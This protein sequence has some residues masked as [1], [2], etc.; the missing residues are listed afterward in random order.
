MNQL[1]HIAVE[2][3]TQMRSNSFVR[4]PYVAN[5]KS[6]SLGIRHLFTQ[7]EVRLLALSVVTGTS[8]WP[9]YLYTYEDQKR[10]F[11]VLKNEVG[12][13]RRLAF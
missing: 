8:E 2:L 11:R 10:G 7:R 4:S 5:K 12:A 3:V 1:T 9:S 13:S 6:K